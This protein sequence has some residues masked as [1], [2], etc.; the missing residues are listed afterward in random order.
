M[1]GFPLAIRAAST[2]LL[3]SFLPG[4]HLAIMAISLL[5]V[6]VFRRVLWIYNA[7]SDPVHTSLLLSI[8]PMRLVLYHT[9][10]A[11]EPLFLVYC[12][13]AF[14]FVRVNRTLPLVL[15]L[16]GA[17]IT[18]VEGLAMWGTVG[19]TLLLRAD[20]RRAT[21]VGF[22]LGAPAAVLAFHRLRF[23][24][25]RAYWRF[26]QGHNGLLAWPPFREVVGD[27]RA[28]GDVPYQMS[29]LTL[30]AV[31]G[32]GVV[33]VFHASVPFGIFSTVY[34]AFVSLLFHLDL[35]RYALPGYI[36]AIFVGFDEVW[37]SKE[38]ARAAKW[39]I[40]GY[41][42]VMGVYA[43]GQLRTNAAAPWFTEWALKASVAYW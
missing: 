1:P 26:N 22:A 10:G 41:V 15:S 18:R 5:L 9:V 14:I 13:L 12:Y 8:L 35:F 37:A 27:A 11:S 23:G 25:W 16:C 7:V 36:F 28:S 17:M 33:C 3:N 40:P 2:I 32:I 29:A 30:F 19:L 24:D 31:F 21:A 42:A 43:V 39:I 4:T 38:F 34:V 6:Y 20:L